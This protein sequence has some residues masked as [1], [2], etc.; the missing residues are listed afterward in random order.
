MRLAVFEDS[1]DPT[2]YYIVGID[3][4]ASVNGALCAIEVFT[5]REFKQVAEAF[6]RIG[7]LHKFAELAKNAVSWLRSQVGDNIVIAIERNSIGQAVVESFQD[8]PEFEPLLY[9]E[10]KRG[11]RIYGVQTTGQTK[12][13]MT[14][15]FYQH[16]CDN[17]SIIRSQDLK[18]QLLN[19]R[20]NNQGNI[21]IP[22]G[23]KSDLFMAACFCAYARKMW[24]SKLISVV[25]VTVSNQLAETL[26]R[27]PVVVKDKPKTGEQHLHDLPEIIYDVDDEQDLRYIIVT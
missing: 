2:D 8:D 27:T 14:S 11:E 22:K 9:Y 18:N 24:Y 10:E 1:F 4:A 19:A 15:L 20:R 3:T 23:Y 12:G 13:I 25:D 21:E 6:G 5:F 7:S 26:S 17:P 16:V